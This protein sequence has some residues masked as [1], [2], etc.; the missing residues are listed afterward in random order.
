MLFE[1]KNYLDPYSRSGHEVRLETA[2]L[3]IPQMGYRKWGMADLRNFSLVIPGTSVVSMF[4]QPD[5]VARLDAIVNAQFEEDVF[6][7]RFDGL[8]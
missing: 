2:T 4:A 7:V 8:E 5:L 1:L 3:N 6:R